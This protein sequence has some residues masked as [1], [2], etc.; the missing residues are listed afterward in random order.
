MASASTW[1]RLAGGSTQ[2]AAL[3]ARF[4]GGR[5]STFVGT[6]EVSALLAN[7]KQED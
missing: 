3:T 4:D 2:P 5:L 1:M 7:P 6:A